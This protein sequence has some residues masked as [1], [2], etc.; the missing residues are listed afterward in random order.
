MT[1]S[2][3]G[4]ARAAEALALTATVLV[5]ATGA[6][7]VGAAADAARVAVCVATSGG[8]ET[9]DVAACETW[10]CVA[11]FFVVMG[12]SWVETLDV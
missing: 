1:A 10:A 5:E 11:I 3:G 9:S 7:L 4:A 8:V 12:T 2:S 6:A